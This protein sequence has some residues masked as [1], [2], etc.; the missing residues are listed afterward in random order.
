[1][2]SANLYYQ[3]QPP[4]PLRQIWLHL[5]ANPW[6]LF[7]LTLLSLW[8]LLMAGATW[9]TP[10]DPLQQYTEMMLQPPA[11]QDEGKIRFLFGTDDL[12]RDLLSRMIAGASYSLGLPLLAVLLAL[13]IGLPIGAWAGMTRGLQSST[14]NHLLDALNAIP[15]LL[16]ALIIIAILGP[17]LINV[18]LALVLV[19]IP[20]FIHET[21]N[22]IRDERYQDYVM[23]SRLNGCS[24]WFLLTRVIFPNITAPMVM[25][26]TLALS[27]AIFDIAA[28]GFLGLGVP[29]PAPEWGSMLARSLEQVYVAPWTMILPGLALFLTL[30]S[31]NILGDSLRSAIQERVEK[32]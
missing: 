3:Q 28:L 8:L 24:R 15:S 29:A 30:L 18:V 2:P 12:G 1:M 7:A 13:L 27:T 21:H 14:L 31:I 22:A 16:L 10:H 17:S 11:W 4:S 26:V 6:A 25:H 9:L 23:A 5:S 32:A 19:L 20:S